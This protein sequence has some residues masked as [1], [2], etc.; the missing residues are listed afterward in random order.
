MNQILLVRHGQDI[1]NLNGVLN[2][3]RNQPLT[4]L[5]EEQATLV[6]Q[7]LLKEKIDRI[8][9]SPLTRARQTAQAIS[10]TLDIPFTIE[11]LLIERDFG[12]MTGKSISSI[13]ELP[14]DQ[15]IKT[16]R[17]NYFLRAQGAESFEETYARAVSL[18]LELHR[19]W[20]DQK[21]LLVT[22][23]DIGKMI[24]AA[25]HEWH[26]TDGLRAPHFDNTDILR[27]SSFT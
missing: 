20:P 5:G 10:S 4:S 15:L 22:H 19:N 17:V 27:L 23:G 18:L 13:K 21:L 2:G 26:W 11:P 8:F 16:A 24:Q 1:D 3:H 6:A 25:Y 14:D 7:K 12:S 9:S